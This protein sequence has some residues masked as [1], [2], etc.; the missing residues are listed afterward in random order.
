MPDYVYRGYE[1]EIRVSD[2][3]ARFVRA[4]QTLY[5]EHAD[6]APGAVHKLTVCVPQLAKR[7]RVPL[8]LCLAPLAVLV[9]WLLY[10]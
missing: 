8:V 2:G 9:A 5:V 4:E 10:R 7:H 1:P 3:A 6:M